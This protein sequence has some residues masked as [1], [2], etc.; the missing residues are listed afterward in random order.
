MFE[1]EEDVA[2]EM[3]EQDKGNQ[4]QIEWEFVAHVPLMDEKTTEHMVV[5]KKKHEELLS[6]DMGEDIMEDQAKAKE[7]LNI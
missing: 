3:G 5:A 1:E 6:K 7:M 4:Q 2:E